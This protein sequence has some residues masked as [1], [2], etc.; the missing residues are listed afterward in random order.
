MGIN[1]VR[2]HTI[3]TEKVIEPAKT[4][5]YIPA[6]DSLLFKS[7]HIPSKNPV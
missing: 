5:K 3:I 1:C 4:A 2:H 7:I 6:T